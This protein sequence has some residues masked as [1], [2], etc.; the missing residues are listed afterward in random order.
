MSE[1]PLVDQTGHM[2]DSRVIVCH[3][4][5]IPT[6]KFWYCGL[7]DRAAPYPGPPLITEREEESR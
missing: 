6:G 3:C 4:P 5:A 2:Q 1:P 7:H